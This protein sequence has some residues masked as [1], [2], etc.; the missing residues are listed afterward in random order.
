MRASI[1]ISRPSSWVSSSPGSMWRLIRAD[2]SVSATSSTSMPPMR[3]SIA[4]SFFSERSRMI[5]A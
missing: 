3:E 2:G 4:S 1:D 5:E